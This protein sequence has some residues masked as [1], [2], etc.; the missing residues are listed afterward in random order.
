M[1]GSEKVYTRAD[2]IAGKIFQASAECN[3]YSVEIGSDSMPVCG[4]DIDLV[5]IRREITEINKRF[6]ENGDITDKE[7]KKLEDLKDRAVTALYERLFD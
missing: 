2:I 6:I 7:I 3:K 5:R 4:A 1:V